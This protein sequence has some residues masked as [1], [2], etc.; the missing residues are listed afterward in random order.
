MNHYC[1]AA[2]KF[3]HTLVFVAIT[4]GYSRRKWYCTL[5]DSKEFYINFQRH[6]RQQALLSQFLKEFLE[7]IT[8]IDANLHRR[9]RYNDQLECALKA[10]CEYHSIMLVF[11]GHSCRSVIS[12]SASVVNMRILSPCYVQDFSVPI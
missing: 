10:L 5:R 12:Y 9:L 11:F 3:I 6:F 7:K 4:Q 1:I 2:V 8:R